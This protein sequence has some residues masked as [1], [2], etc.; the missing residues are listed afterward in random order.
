M[1]VSGELDDAL[2]KIVIDLPSHF[3]LDLIDDL[4]GVGNPQVALGHPEVVEELMMGVQDLVE[5]AAFA[6]DLVPGDLGSAFKGG[7]EREIGG[8]ENTSVIVPGGDADEREGD[9]F[10]LTKS[11][12]G[13]SPLFGVPEDAEELFH[14]SPLIPTVGGVF[15][16]LLVHGIY[17]LGGMREEGV[18]RG[19]AEA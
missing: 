13:D 12:S 4:I 19:N 6:G 9:L 3:A 10:L 2:G 17:R 11:D 18:C 8:A 7:R 14:S 5:A 15:E 16:P 1:A